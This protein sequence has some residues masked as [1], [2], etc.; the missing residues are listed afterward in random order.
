MKQPD[1]S[2]LPVLHENLPVLEVAEAL[3]LDHLLIDPTMGDAV[4]LRPDPEVA[5]LDPAKVDAV[6]ERL[7]KLGH[8]PKVV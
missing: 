5:V 2:A 3:T 1:L 7:V 8:L 4:V 6:V